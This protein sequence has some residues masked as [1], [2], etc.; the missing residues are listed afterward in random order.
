MIRINEMY[1]Y[2]DIICYIRNF[3]KAFTFYYAI[4]MKNLM[5]YSLAIKTLIH[6]KTNNF[7]FFLITWLPTTMNISVE[8]FLLTRERAFLYKD[9][10]IVHIIPLVNQGRI[11]AVSAFV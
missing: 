10:R 8:F 4:I 6:S 2:R 5:S 3:L 7:L 9:I 11:K 1:Q